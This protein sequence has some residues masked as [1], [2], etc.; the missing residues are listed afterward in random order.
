MPVRKRQK[1]RRSK[2]R[3]PLKSRTQVQML[4]SVHSKYYSRMA[5]T[6]QARSNVSVW[7]CLACCAPAWQILPRI[8]QALVCTAKYQSFLAQ[9]CVGIGTT[10][11][12]CTVLYC[13]VGTSRCAYRK[14]LTERIARSGRVMGVLLSGL[15]STQEAPLEIIRLQPRTANTA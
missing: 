11:L 5:R 13:T 4:S 1:W 7:R 6:N 15:S 9:Q 2:S 14:R 8:Q 10:H 12:Y 3:C